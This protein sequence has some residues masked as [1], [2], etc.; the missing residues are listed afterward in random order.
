MLPRD[1]DVVGER[2]RHRVRDRAEQRHVAQAAL[3]LFEIGLEQ[4]GDVAELLVPVGDR[5][6]QDRCPPSRVL[7]RLIAHAGEHAVGQLV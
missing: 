3:P 5:A 4:E 7:L 2:D 6:G 1:V